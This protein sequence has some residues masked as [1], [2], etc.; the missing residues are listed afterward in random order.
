MENSRAE[1]EMRKKAIFDGMSERRRKHIVKIG[2]DKWDPFI[3]PQDPID[4]RKD[5]TRRTSQ[6]LITEFLQS[7][8]LDTYSNE[9]GR[10]AFEICLGIINEEQRFQGMYDFACWYKSLLEKE[11][12]V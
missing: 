2:Y 1:V 5:K 3:E 6:Q 11:K 10:G 4:I 9:Y 8:K 12:T 7:R